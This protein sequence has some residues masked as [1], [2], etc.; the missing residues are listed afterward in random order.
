[1]PLTVCVVVLGK[2]VPGLELVG[3]LLADTTSLPPEA[4]YY[5]RLL[6]RDR[7]EALDLIDRY[8]KAEGPDTVY[9]ALLLPALNYAERD[10]F[11]KR[12]SADEEEAI[13]E[14]TRELMEDAATLNRSQRLS[15]ATDQIE[16]APSPAITHTVPGYPANS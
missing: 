12:L 14:A 16:E 9:D 6:A 13:I 15:T 1:I 8:I 11:E 5:Q 7:M 4:S 3:T 10:R 2:H